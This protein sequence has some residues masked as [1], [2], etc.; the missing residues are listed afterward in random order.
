MVRPSRFA[1]H[2]RAAGTNA[3]MHEPGEDPGTVA[4]RAGGEFEAL[5]SAVEGAGVRVLVHEDRDGLPDCVFPNNWMSWHEPESGEPVLVTYPMLDPLRRR[6]RRGVVLEE[7]V[8]FTG[9][10]PTKMDL[11]A[12]ETRGDFLEGT[13][14]LV[15]DRTRGV[16]LACRSPRTTERGLRAFAE[17]TGYEIVAFDAQ[18]GH[19]DPVYHTNVIA[20]IG[21]RV[22]VVCT[23]AIADTGQRERVLS[24]LGAGGRRV[25]DLAWDQIASMCGNMIELA[26]RAGDP[27]FVMS[28]GALSALG[29]D[30][31][32][33]LGGLGV[34]AH[35]PI[36]TIERVGGGS[37]RCMIAELGSSDL[38][39][40]DLGSD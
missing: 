23:G 37:A 33:T 1:Y 3:F 32:R 10:A 18:D 13:G 40:S 14:S 36:P 29:D 38:R 15:L 6:E 39:S 24:V 25:V 34:I 8:R 2:E 35:A 21:T 4:A 9:V 17:R 19:G 12:L 31:R 16:A 27:V 30:H 5:A 20:S 11:S 22:A 28:S 7:V 26:S